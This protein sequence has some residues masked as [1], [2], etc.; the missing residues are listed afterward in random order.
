MCRGAF[1]GIARAITKLV[2][3]GTH[4]PGKTPIFEKMHTIN[5][6][7]LMSLPGHIFHQ[8]SG[9]KFKDTRLHRHMYIYSLLIPSKGLQGRSPGNFL[10]FGHFNHLEVAVPATNYD[11]HRPGKGNC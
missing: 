3:K 7:S 11:T 4:N 6:A 8:I 1:W 9:L 5:R 2:K 10:H